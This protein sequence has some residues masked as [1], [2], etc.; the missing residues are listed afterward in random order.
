MFIILKRYKQLILTHQ[1]ILLLVPQ[2]IV[3]LVFLIEKTVNSKL[4]NTMIIKINNNTYLRYDI[5]NIRR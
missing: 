5:I 2:K 3:Q 4:N 1:M